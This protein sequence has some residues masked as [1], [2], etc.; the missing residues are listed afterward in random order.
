MEPYLLKSYGLRFT[1]LD[2]S[3]Y[4]FDWIKQERHIIAKEIGQKTHKE[5]YQIYIETNACLK[6]IR[7]RIYKNFKIPKGGVGQES[8]HYAITPD[9]KDTLYFWKEG[10]IL[11]QN[12][13]DQRDIPGLIAKAKAKW[14][15]AEEQSP[16]TQTIIEVREKTDNTWDRLLDELEDDQMNDNKMS[17]WLITDFKYNIIA[18]Y[19]RRRKPP[20]RDADLKRY[21]Y[22]LY[23]IK[24]TDKTK[25]EITRET[26]E[27]KS[28]LL[29]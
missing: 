8:A 21:S 26:V 18:N 14:P 5:H 4:S 17:K 25:T 3:G 1:P 11:S 22:A 16:V 19:L 27:Q 15:P 24:E 2:L 9:W 13:V 6:T 7:N 12:I 10:N 20:P 29:L 28:N 23:M